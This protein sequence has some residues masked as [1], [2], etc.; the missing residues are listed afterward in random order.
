MAVSMCIDLWR[1]NLSHVWVIIF[2]TI[3]VGQWILCAPFGGAAHRFGEKWCKIFAVA[4]YLETLQ[5]IDWH[6]SKCIDTFSISH[7]S[8]TSEY[9]LKIRF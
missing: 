3:K 2:K 5:T 1:Q 4:L 6:G 7:W 8:L 9:V